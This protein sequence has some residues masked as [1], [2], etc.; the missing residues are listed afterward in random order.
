MNMNRP[1][2]TAI[3]FSLLF[4][5]PLLELHATHVHYRGSDLVDVFLLLGRE[6]QHVEGLLFV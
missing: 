6:T 2:F 4:T 5:S 3:C 1:Y